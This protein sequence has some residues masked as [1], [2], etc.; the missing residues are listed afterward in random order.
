M[1]RIMLCMLVLALGLCLSAILSTRAYAILSR[2]TDA[3]LTHASDQIV[4][5]QVIGGESK[6]NKGRSAI[7]TEITLE[8]SECIKGDKGRRYV[9]FRIPGGVVGDT[10]VWAEEQPEF[11]KGEN[12]L[13]FL[14]ST[15]G[16]ILIADQYQHKEHLGYGESIS[17]K[18]RDRLVTKLRAIMQGE[19][20]E[21]EVPE[22]PPLPRAK[23]LQTITS[24]SPTTASA[25][26]T[27]G[28]ITINGTDFGDSVMFNT[29]KFIGP[30]DGT[31]YTKDFEIT[32]AY[33]GLFLSWSSTKIEFKPDGL[34]ID[35]GSEGLWPGK[36]TINGLSSGPII[37]EPQ[38][39]D[40]SDPSSDTLRVTFSHV[41]VCSEYV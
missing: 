13:V 24:I 2:L 11:S 37:V 3:E 17:T 7:Y 34:L 27:G 12:V 30:G 19:I 21:E 8:V 4:I 9:T 1:K 20:P 35:H 28:D 31:E 14:R 22:Q 32:D 10:V 36:L 26:G 23:T 5:G 6:W 38:G 41:G 29:I 25:I 33:D 18:K 15:G 40:E 16:D 39:E